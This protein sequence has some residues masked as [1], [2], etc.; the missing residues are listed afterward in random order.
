[1]YLPTANPNHV[2]SAAGLHHI[3]LVAIVL[4]LVYLLG[5]AILQVSRRLQ[6]YLVNPVE[7]TARGLGYALFR[8]FWLCLFLVSGIGGAL[9]AFK[10]NS[11]LLRWD[12]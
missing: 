11:G 5:A 10:P 8:L 9:H 12:K 1:M 7:A 4:C 3:L 2:R 6:Q